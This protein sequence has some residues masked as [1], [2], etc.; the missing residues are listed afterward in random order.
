MGDAIEETAIVQE[1]RAVIE[2]GSMIKVTSIKRTL[3]VA[4]AHPAKRQKTSVA[5]Q[6]DSIPFSLSTFKESLSKTGSTPTE[7]DLLALECD[8]MDPSWL[9][10]LSSELRKD[11]FLMLKKMLWTEGVQGKDTPTKSLKV[12]PPGLRLREIDSRKLIVRQPAIS[13]PGRNCLWTR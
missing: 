7:S 11:Y 2:E 12:F 5:S 9:K 13:I 3:E 4:S 1:N 10:I 8:T 6:L